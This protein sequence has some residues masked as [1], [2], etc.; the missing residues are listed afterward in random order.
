MPTPE[1]PRGPASE[2]MRNVIHRTFFRAGVIIVEYMANLD[3]VGTGDFEFV[4]LPLR[5]EG[6]DGS[7]VRAVA[8]VR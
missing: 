4:I 7:P 8:I 1:D 6:L 3:D 5:L 2:D